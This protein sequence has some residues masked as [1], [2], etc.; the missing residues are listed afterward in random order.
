V[1]PVRRRSATG[2]L[3]H[4]E[5]IKLWAGYINSIA[6]SLIAVGVLAPLVGL[7]ATGARIGVWQ[8][9]LLLLGCVV[10]SLALNYVARL[11]LKGLV[12]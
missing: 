7:V 11:V 10:L 2:K 1:R 5:Q 12:E 3:V 6:V 4:N 9:L 8:L